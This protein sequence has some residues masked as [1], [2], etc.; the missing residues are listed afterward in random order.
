M[1][2]VKL[3][4]RSSTLFEHMN[5][6]KNNLDFIRFFAATLVVFSHA[7]P[8]STGNNKTEPFYLLSNGQS[9]LGH[10]A[11]LVFFVTSGFLITQSYE[12]NPDIIRYTK[13]RILRLFP[14]LAFYMILITFIIGPIITS[15]PLNDYFSDKSTFTYLLNVLLWPFSN[16]LPG[17]FD[18]NIYAN[19]ING[20]LWSLKY[21]FL[22]YILV[23]LLGLAKILNRTSVIILTSISIVLSLSPLPFGEL[24]S[25]VP[26]MFNYFGAGMLIYLFRKKIPLSGILAL[27]S[28]IT[29]TASLFVG[30]FNELFIVFGSYL[31]IYLSYSSKVKVHNFSKYGD[32]SY[33]IYIFAFPIQ[34]IIV[35]LNHGEMLPIMNF[36]IS[37]PFILIIAVVSWYLVEKRA[38]KLNYINVTSVEKKL[39]KI[40][41]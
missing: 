29:L 25:L 30:Y 23:A 41:S 17:V 5:G 7:F 12:R 21:E 27:L 14:G 31:I 38:L 20:S 36:L 28:F 40:P 2:C 19:S 4:S 37:F 22:F 6:R 16:Q 1:E 3:M 11:V 15:I 13:A 9:T 34:Q 33:G 24:I 35:S 39:V 18:N 26:Y 8:L 10:I 32:F